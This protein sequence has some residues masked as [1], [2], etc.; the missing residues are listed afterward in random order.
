MYYDA[1]KRRT[2][3]ARHLH[4]THQLTGVRR[5]IVYHIY[6]EILDSIEHDSFLVPRRPITAQVTLFTVRV[7]GKNVFI[8]AHHRSGAQLVWCAKCVSKEE[9]EEMEDVIKSAVDLVDLKCEPIKYNQKR[10]RI[11][12]DYQGV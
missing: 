6:S 8:N 4:V 5:R 10:L 11:F 7:D 12:I 2:Q 9:A 3:Q 1:L